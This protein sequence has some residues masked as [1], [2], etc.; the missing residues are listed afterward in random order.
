MIMEELR[1][2]FGDYE[3]W[4]FGSPQDFLQFADIMAWLEVDHRET[5]TW[6]VKELD[7]AYRGLTPHFWGDAHE[8]AEL[9]AG[10]C[11][12]QLP[13][14]ADSAAWVLSQIRRTAPEDLPLGIGMLA[15]LARFTDQH[16]EDIERYLACRQKA[17]DKSRKAVL[18]KFFK[19]ETGEKKGE[20]ER[21]VQCVRVG[22]IQ[23]LPCRELP[24]CDLVSLACGHSSKHEDV[25]C[26]HVPADA[27]ACTLRHGSRS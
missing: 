4:E 11:H 24:C 22:F 2:G 9:A 23:V 10:C 13:P 12:K 25:S 26:Q 15:S 1:R 6:A 27:A 18:R 7:Y 19:T 8:A 14:I 5:Y 3:R 16:G 17:A 20:S 21:C